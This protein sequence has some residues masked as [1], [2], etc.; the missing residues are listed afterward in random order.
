LFL[1]KTVS[2]KFEDTTNK[3]ADVLSSESVESLA[4]HLII[5][6]VPSWSLD[7]HKALVDLYFRQRNQKSGFR[8]PE[9]FEAGIILALAE[10]YRQASKVEDAKS[11]LSFAIDNALN[12]PTLLSIERQFDGRAPIDWGVLIPSRQSV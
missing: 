12:F 3:N 6:K 11:L 7:D 4:V 9:L 10:R 5:E 2:A 1:S 8:M